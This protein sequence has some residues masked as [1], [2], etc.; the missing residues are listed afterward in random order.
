VDEAALQRAMQ[1]AARR[2]GRMEPMGCHALRRT[3][4]AHLLDDGYDIRTVRELL[5][6]WDVKTTMSYT[7]LLNRGGRVIY[8]PV[9]RLR[10][11]W[12]E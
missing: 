3:C 8:S 7:H 6:H 11:E 2:V 9:E 12:A 5:G 10:T 1:E 4:A